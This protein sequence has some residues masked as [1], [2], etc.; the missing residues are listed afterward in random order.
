MHSVSGG[1]GQIPAPAWQDPCEGAAEQ[2]LGLGKA[3]GTRLCSV[4]SCLAA[5]RWEIGS[6][7]ASLSTGASTAMDPSWAGST[8]GARTCEGAFYSQ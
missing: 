5:A 2:E 4:G 7:E 3:V 6:G 8:P 1:V